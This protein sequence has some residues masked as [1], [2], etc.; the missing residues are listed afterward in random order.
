MRERKGEGEEEREREKDQPYLLQIHTEIF[1][2]E[3]I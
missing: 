3:I 2:D 1:T